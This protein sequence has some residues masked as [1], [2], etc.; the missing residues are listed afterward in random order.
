MARA[1][2]APLNKCWADEHA[3]AL[4][5]AYY[6]GEQGGN[7]VADVL[8]GDC[9]PGGRLPVTVP[10]HVGQLPVYYNRPLP[11]AH[12]YVDLSAQPLYPFGYGLSYTTFRYGEMTV[13]ETSDGYDVAVELTN[14]G[15]RRGDEVVQLYVHHPV[16]PVVQPERQ[17]VAF[18][19]VTLEPGETRRVTLH[20]ARR[21]V[22]IVNSQM[23]WESAPVEF[24]C[25]P[26]SPH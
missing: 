25:N 12:D 4:L 26:H 2:T 8:L 7:A 1:A 6:P 22:Q 9:D 10:R 19:R 20:V 11:A 23:Q 3:N 15:S 14:T 24:V 18:E 17:L 5:T 13:N 21:A 16:A